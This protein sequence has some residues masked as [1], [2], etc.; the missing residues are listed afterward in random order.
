MTAR[1]SCC[2]LVRGDGRGEVRGEGEGRRGRGK[3]EEEEEEEEERE[4][5]G[6]I[7]SGDAWPEIKWFTL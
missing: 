7:L 1:R 4:E 6:M 5:E 2:S 3:G